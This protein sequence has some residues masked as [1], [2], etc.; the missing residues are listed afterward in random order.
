VSNSSAKISDE[1]WSEFGSFLEKNG[2]RLKDADE[3]RRGIERA[4][5]EASKIPMVS[6]S[7][8]AERKDFLRAANLARKLATQ[9]KGKIGQLG[10]LGCGRH[11]GTDPTCDFV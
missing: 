1:A 7:E 6:K 4:S 3:L 11:E 8:M 5:L 2:I 9:T 10:S